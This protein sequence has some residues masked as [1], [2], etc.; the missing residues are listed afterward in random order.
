LPDDSNGVA[1]FDISGKLILNQPATNVGAVSFDVSSIP[2]GLY[3]VSFES[4]SQPIKHPIIIQ[5]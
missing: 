4:G 5:H 1:L 2:S 3:L